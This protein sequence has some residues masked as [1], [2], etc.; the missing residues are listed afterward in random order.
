MLSPAPLPARAASGRS[1][2]RELGF[3]P[4]K[5]KPKNPVRPKKMQTKELNNGRLA[6]I[7]IAGMLVQEL[8]NGQ[9]ILG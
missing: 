2:A 9:D 1:T 7:G 8:V 6:M 5:I 3:D 4:A